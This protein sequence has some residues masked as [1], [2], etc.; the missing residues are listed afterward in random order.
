MK[1]YKYLSALGAAA[2][3]VLL[4]FAQFWRLQNTKDKL[5]TTESKLNQAKAANDSI[6][7]QAEVL[8][9]RKEDRKQRREETNRSN[10]TPDDFD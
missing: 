10:F 4:F 6:I 8:A 7:D 2:A 1:I 9:D 5:K 3:A